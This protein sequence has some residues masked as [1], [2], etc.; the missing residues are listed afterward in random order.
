M[1]PIPRLAALRHELRVLGPLLFAVPL[2][3]ALGFGGLV[4]ALDARNT[5]HDFLAQLLT[6]ILEACLPLTAGI[7]IATV[8]ARDPAL[9]VQL[10]LPTP[11]R[12]TALRRFALL[13][14]W[15]ILVEAATALALQLTLPWA[16]PKLGV[17]YVLL[18]LAPTLWF[19][20]AGGLLALL[21]RSRAT[22]GALLGSIW[23]AQLVFHGY[24]ALN[25]WTR[26]WF[27]FVTLFAPGASYWLANRVELIVTAAVV[28]LGVWG[29]LFNTEWR[30]R[31]EEV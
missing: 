30:F 3:A 16:Q 8:A 26:P 19:A 22:A 10:S 9:E 14:G 4:G 5:S 2:L 24:F 13:L 1:N 27:L 12:R 28:S 29:F 23:V 31:G 25:S 21:M 7:L 11:Y 20:A 17:W 15:T 6:A 18:W